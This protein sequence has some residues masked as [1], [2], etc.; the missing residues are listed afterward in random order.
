[1]TD[2]VTPEEDKPRTSGTKITSNAKTDFRKT[3]APR[4]KTNKR[5]VYQSSIEDD[6]SD[7][8][9]ILSTP[10]EEFDYLPSN[11]QKTNSPLPGDISVV[12]AYGKSKNVRLAMQRTY[13]A[14]VIQLQ[15]DGYVGFFYKMSLNTNS[16]TLTNEES[17]FKNRRCHQVADATYQ[18]L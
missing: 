2:F 12:K 17:F 5:S 1:M 14:K 15:D 16:F 9:L 18:C 10:L 4:K 8:D 13:I 11:F 7:P 6:V 3:T